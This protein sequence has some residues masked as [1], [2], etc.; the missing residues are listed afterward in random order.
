[1]L[2]P[3]SFCLR[4]DICHAAFWHNAVFVRAAPEFLAESLIGREK[5]LNEQNCRFERLLFCEI[6]GPSYLQGRSATSGRGAKQQLQA[7]D[8]EPLNV[9]GSSLPLKVSFPGSLLIISW[10]ELSDKCLQ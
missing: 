1:M 2:N 9:A 6:T 7:S 3:S 10:K 5:G 8:V 4:R